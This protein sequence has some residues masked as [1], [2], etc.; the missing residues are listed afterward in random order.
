MLELTICIWSNLIRMLLQILS[1]SKWNSV[2]IFNTSQWD[3]YLKKKSTIWKMLRKSNF[4]N[5]NVQKLW[6]NHRKKFKQSG[7]SFLSWMILLDTCE[8]FQNLF[9][10]CKFSKFPQ[11]YS[12]VTSRS[13]TQNFLKIMSNFTTKTFVTW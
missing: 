2:R 4:H 12:Y 9:K 7:F 5:E 6:K 3:K 8:F 1:Q 11:S 13:I 10:F